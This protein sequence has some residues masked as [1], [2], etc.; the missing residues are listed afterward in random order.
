MLPIRTQAQQAIYSIRPSE[1]SIQT[2]MP[3]RAN[4]LICVSG[5]EK[6]LGEW[7]PRFLSHQRLS[8]ERR[9]SKIYQVARSGRAVESIPGTTEVFSI[10]TGSGSVAGAAGSTAGPRAGAGVG[11]VSI[12]GTAIGEGF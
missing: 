5:V 1:K 8:R 7:F 4:D 12:G 9:D 11:I 10:V 6:M 2:R 3:M